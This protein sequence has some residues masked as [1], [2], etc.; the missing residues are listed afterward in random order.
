MKAHSNCSVVIRLRN[1][2]ISGSTLVKW[3]VF[4]GIAFLLIAGV[5]FC[6]CGCR[7]HSDSMAGA[8]KA[9][10]GTLSGFLISYQSTHDGKLP[11]SITALVEKGIITEAMSKDPWGNPYQLVVP[12]Q[13]SK[14][15]FDLFSLGK[16]INDESD[17]I[18][19]WDE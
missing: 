7:D 19:N 16:K 3:M 15:K 11:A 13:R 10:I 5:R 17:N 18:G 14:D 8:A 1:V 12:A 6:G 2:C 9:D 4:L